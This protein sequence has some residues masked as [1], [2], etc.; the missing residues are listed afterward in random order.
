M[1]NVFIS[2][3]ESMRLYDDFKT[4]I[5]SLDQILDK[6]DMLHDIIEFYE[7]EN[8]DLKK[9]IREIDPNYNYDV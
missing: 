6:Y 3:D 9:T 4:N 8:K 2:T 7:Q 5:V 1:K